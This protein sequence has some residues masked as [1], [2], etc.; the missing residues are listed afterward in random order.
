MW[1]VKGPRRA[2]T[3]LTKK[4]KTN[5]PQQRTCIALIKLTIKLQQS[6]QFDIGVKKD[7]QING[8]ELSAETDTH[9]YGQLISTKLLK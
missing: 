9:L 7:I 2:K 6:K 8:T 4:T 1:K 5:K 3:I